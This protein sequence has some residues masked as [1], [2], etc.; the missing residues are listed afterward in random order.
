MLSLPPLCVLFFGV[1]W[2][3]AGGPFERSPLGM[4]VEGRASFNARKAV[5]RLG[6]GPVG[7]VFFEGAPRGVPLVG[8]GGVGGRPDAPDGGEAGRLARKG[9]GTSKGRVV[10]L[11]PEAL[12]GWVNLREGERVALPWFGEAPLFG[13]AFLRM[14]DM[15]WLRF[16]GALEGE[17]GSFTLNLRA[18]EVNGLI[19]FPN[20]GTALE[21]RTEPGGTALLVERPLDTRMCWPA[22]AA[23]ASGGFAETAA[24]S[25]ATV[26][27]V[28]TRPGARGLIYINFEGG[29][30]TEPSWNY[31]K[32]IVFARSELTPSGVLEV[33][34]R[35]AE[36][37]APFDMAVS[38]ILADYEAAPVGRRTRVI[39]TPT[40]TALPG[41]GGV[42]MINAWSAA[43]RTMSSTVPAWVFASSPKYAAEGVSH[44]VGH[45]LGLNHDGTEPSAGRPGLAYYRGH[46]GDV[47]DL[48]SWAPIMG[49][50]YARSQTHWSRG[51][52][53]AANNPEDDIATIKRKTN[54]VGS[55]EGSTAGPR[56][57]ELSGRSFEVSG[58]VH[59]SE[60]SK[61][62]AFST[63][64][65]NFNALLKPK[66]ARY[67]NTDLKMEVLDREG[68][69]LAVSDPV[70]ATAAQLK[71]TLPEGT[72]LL[73]VS[74]G[75]TG[76]KPVGGY[77]TG[78]PS[79]GALG[80]YV[81]EGTLE[82]PAR[83]PDLTTP[84]AVAAVVGAPF[85][86]R[87]GLTGGAM[88]EEYLGGAPLGV[89][90][91]PREQVLGGTPVTEGIYEA[92]FSLVE[93]ARRIRRT[94]RITVTPDGLPVLVSGD[95]A[96]VPVTTPDAPWR[97][98]LEELPWASFA[99]S[100]GLVAS[101]GFA[102]DGAASRLRYSLPAG[103]VVHFWW[104]VS[105][106]SGCDF[107]ECR[108]NG[109]LAQDRDSGALL[110]L[111]GVRDWSR[112][113]VQVEGASVL[114]FV[115]RK[116]FSLSEEQDR[117]WVAGLELGLLP[118][119]TKMPQSQRLQAGGQAFALEARVEHATDYQWKK[120]G[121]SLLDGESGG[122]R[123]SGART[124][125]LQVTG[126]GVADSGGY[127]LEARNALGTRSSRRA[128]V[129][130]P[131]APVVTQQISGV[132]L[133]KAGDTLVLSV[134][135]ACAKP[136]FV[137]WSK[138][139]R[140]LRWTQSPVYQLRAADASMSGRYSAVVINAY[141]SEGAG[142][143]SVQ[144]R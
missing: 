137:A 13:T 57:L 29:V 121:V 115:Y 79:Y 14:E 119:F 108:V 138:D 118:V 78:Y 62:Y 105:S 133:V 144:I 132:G 58:V 131:G 53:A 26:P 66:V 32:P 8:R 98:Q 135:I 104:K 16:G 56:A 7:G 51:E 96:A 61:V 65:G 124:A 42:A 99:S 64:G 102:A 70:A 10:A 113:G 86:Y 47:D 71:M 12:Q 87:L 117:G 141:G 109:V 35:V 38:T 6:D 112:Q 67:G 97:A 23:A 77:V 123:I 43:G 25:G 20:T 30:T 34:E 50:S 101:S 92:G 36:D 24:S 107:L 49:E 116:D 125:A 5:S 85:L 139:G 75:C 81:L 41:S 90:W 22:M 91:D 18:G 59:Q 93:G 103:G 21:I 73:A 9:L 31:G 63:L 55:S 37:Y 76:P 88:V 48:L 110:R 69:V 60:A 143:V 80:H 89:D 134:G 83:V 72:Y 100:K 130:V 17:E 52:Y 95:A 2:W 129:G 136:F 44:E 39:V 68:A 84:L 94:L 54:G 140:L 28:N 15:G 122:R 3:M 11:R 40:S 111:S 142:E 46:G 114:E 126:A 74:A 127:V 120:D 4:A 128:E 106:E 19:L 45:T 27:Q 82:N 1:Y 33:V